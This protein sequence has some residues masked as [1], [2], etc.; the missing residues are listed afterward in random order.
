[1]A[2][3]TCGIRY[4]PES[5]LFFEDIRSCLIPPASFFSLQTSWGQQWPVILFHPAPPPTTLYIHGTHVLPHLEAIELLTCLKQALLL[6]GNFQPRNRYY[7]NNQF[8]GKV[9]WTLK[10]VCIYYLPVLVWYV[11]F[12]QIQI[13]V[14]TMRPGKL[15][16]Y[17]FDIEFDYLKE[18]PGFLRASVEATVMNFLGW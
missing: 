9:Y 10:Y 17:S 11:R 16:L 7:I 15:N 14:Y 3:W 18:Y 4:L 6:N 1:M 13:R 5:Y 12:G 2:L 8:K